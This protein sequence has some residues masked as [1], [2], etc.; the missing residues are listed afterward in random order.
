MIAALRPLPIVLA[1]CLLATAGCGQ[2]RVG[3]VLT[4]K[5]DREKLPAGTAADMPAVL[6]AVGRRVN[7]GWRS[8]GKVT[9][10]GEEICIYVF[11]DPGEPRPADEIEQIVASSGSLEFR[12]AAN[13]HDHADII[14]R[15]EA[16]SAQL[17]VDD[18]KQPLGR[19]VPAN[20]SLAEEMLRGWG[21]TVRKP[22]DGPAE[23]L[24]VLD[25]MNVNGWDL[26]SASANTDD[27][28]NPFVV[29]EL[30]RDGAKRL[31]ALTSANLP[32][33]VLKLKRQM[34]IILD[35]FLMT[36]PTINS[37]ISDRGSITGNF[38]QLQAQQ[39]AAVLMA[40]VLPVPLRLVSR[41]SASGD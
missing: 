9:Q 5:I 15:A 38:S 27:A 12:I 32:D 34:A 31:A 36:A 22:S 11:G 19:W 33:P 10:E 6:R 40:G 35:G 23:V 29:F 39:T 17:V 41:V 26:Q 18:E 8:R 37:V 24:V 7:P 20:K 16:S 21:L 30:N 1:V 4:Y 28:G 2:R 13:Q 25:S 14:Q 3:W